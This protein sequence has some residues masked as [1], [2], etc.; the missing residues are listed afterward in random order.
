VNR[1][2]AKGVAKSVTILERQGRKL[3][4]DE[5]VKGYGLVA[6]F[7]GCGFVLFAVG[8]GGLWGW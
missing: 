3:T 5:E 8:A 2:D 7:F 1:Q 6:G 4:E